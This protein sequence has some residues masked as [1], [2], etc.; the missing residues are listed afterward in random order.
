MIS[1]KELDAWLFLDRELSHLESYRKHSKEL[2]STMEE[3]SRS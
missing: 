2:L 3:P 1:E